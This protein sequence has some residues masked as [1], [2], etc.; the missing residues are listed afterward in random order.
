MLFSIRGAVA[1]LLLCCPIFGGSAWAAV[2]SFSGTGQVSPTGPPDAGGNL[3]LMVFTPTTNYNLGAGGA[4]QLG[5]SFTSNLVMGVGFGG[6]T[7]TRGADSLSGSLA[8]AFGPGPGQFALTYSVTGGTGIYAGFQGS[9]SSIVQ[10]LGRSKRTAYSLL[11]KWKSDGRP[12]S[13]TGIARPIGRWIGRSSSPRAR[14]PA[15][16]K[17]APNQQ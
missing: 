4:W 3:P 2:I 10:L 16:L 13:G 8:A 1:A 5:S 11:R 17:F 6:F 9:G 7:F 15:T 14:S 12:R